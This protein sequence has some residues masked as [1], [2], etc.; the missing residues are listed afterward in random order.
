MHFY[1]ALAMIRQ[2]WVFTQQNVASTPLR[3]ISIWFWNRKIWFPQ[4]WMKMIWRKFRRNL[5]TPISLFLA[6][7]IKGKVK[8]INA[9]LTILFYWAAKRPCNMSITESPFGFGWF[10]KL[11]KFTFSEGWV[12]SRS[13]QSFFDDNGRLFFIEQFV[14]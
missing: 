3:Q 6:R 14:N 2:F 10:E 1:S 4:D 13:I 8:S 9:I 7:M 5:T 11:P 12:R